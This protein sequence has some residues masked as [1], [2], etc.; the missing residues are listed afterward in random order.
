M[1][2]AQLASSIALQ[3]WVHDQAK[4]P[5]ETYPYHPNYKVVTSMQHFEFA[6]K[7]CPLQGIRGQTD[8][9]QDGVRGLMKKYQLRDEGSDP[10]PP[11]DPVPPTGQWPNGWTTSGLTKRFGGL[12]RFSDT[13]EVKEMAFNEKGPISN[14]WVA[15]GEK[16]GIKTVGK[17]PKPLRWSRMNTVPDGI[18]D[19]IVFDVPVGK[20]WVLYGSSEK[21]RAGFM[22]VQ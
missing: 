14:L 2:S 13:G 18:I 21:D 4:Q 20:N 22:W 19:I 15:R 5:W 17:L 7:P 1:T 9:Y 6:T 8:L 16:E 11:V 3:A 12:I 10:V